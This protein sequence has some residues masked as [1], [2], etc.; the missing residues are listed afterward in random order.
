MKRINT[1]GLAVC[2][3]ALLIVAL[4]VITLMTFATN[5]G[6]GRYEWAIESYIWMLQLMPGDRLAVLFITAS[7]LSALFA[8]IV[9]GGSILALVLDGISYLR[10]RFLS[11]T[12]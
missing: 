11:S 8:V 1:S 4:G 7:E 2:V 6:F 12:R 5:A 10:R 3:I 9:I